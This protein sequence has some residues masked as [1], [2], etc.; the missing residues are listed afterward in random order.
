M[1]EKNPDLQRLLPRGG[2]SQI[3]K[4][5]G[6]TRQAVSLAIKSAKPG[7]PAVI[8][9]MNIARASGALGAAQDIATLNAA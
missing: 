4:K 2:I 9:A 6:I 3:A 5:L 8:E 7:N 1:Q